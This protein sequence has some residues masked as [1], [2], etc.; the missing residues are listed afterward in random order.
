MRLL[1]NIAATACLALLFASNGQAQSVGDTLGG[2]HWEV[3][4]VATELLMSTLFTARAATQGEA[5]QAAQHAFI[6][7]DDAYSHPFYWAAFSIVGDSARA[8]P[9]MSSTARHAQAG[10]IDGG[11]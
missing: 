10:K 2:V 4:S 9:N 5:L 8:M 6:V 7:R 3:D 1:K 11:S